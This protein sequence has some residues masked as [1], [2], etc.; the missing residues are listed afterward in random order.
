MIKGS[1]GWLLHALLL[2]VAFVILTWH[3]AQDVG[4][5][6]GA[7]G[8]ICGVLIAETMVAGRYRMWVI[9]V[10]GF[11]AIGLGWI[12]ARG[13]LGSITL[14]T[15]LGPGA[16]IK[17][18][19]V[20]RWSSAALGTCIIVRGTALRLR[21]A[22]AVEGS[23]AVAAVVATV[24]A[25]RDGM[26]AR[27]L[28]VSD[29]FWRQG[30]DPVV[31][32]L[33]VGIGAAMLVAGLLLHGRSRRR[34]LIQLSLVLMLALYLMSSIHRQE[35]PIPQK[36]AIG[37]ELEKSQDDPN[38]KSTGGGGT[39]GEPSGSSDQNSDLP[40]ASRQ[41]QN[42]PAAVVVFHRDVK[43]SGEVFYFRQASF[44]QF[45]GHRLVEATRPG[46]DTGGRLGFP[47]EPRSVE[48]APPSTSARTE[49]L[50]D[51]ALLLNHNRPFALLDP[52]QL[53]PKA[54]PDP[55]RFKR[56]YSVVSQVVTADPVE[57]LSNGAGDP[58]WDDQDWKLYTELPRDE[59]YYRL[60]TS[61]QAELRQEYNQSP[62]ALALAV[63]QHLEETS[64]YSFA[65]KYEGDEPTADFLF[66]E[67]R[68]G[69]C[70]HLAHSAAYL[71]RALGLPARVSAGYA[72]ESSN[73]S[74]GSALL[75]KQNHGHAWAEVYL[76]GVGWIPI[77]VTPQQ[78]DV[79]P[80][81]FEER[82]LQQLLGE[83]ARQEPPERRSSS[84]EWPILSWLSVLWA[85][86]PWLL[87]ALVVV[88]YII[89]FWRLLAPQFDARRP[90][91]AYRAALDR[92]SA[93]G[94]TRNHGE[95]REV[96]AKRVGEIAPSL[97]P[98]TAGLSGY[99]LGSV[100]PPEERAGAPLDRL[101]S[102]VGIEVRK[103]VPAW[104]WV[105]GMLNPLSWWWSR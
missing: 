99:V 26:I 84:S 51:V 78:T 58:G 54:N 63:K 61:L 65:R 62:L 24:A 103:A 102:T 19:E 76:T 69:Y 56:A 37:Q 93:V 10:T 57:F 33:T 68:K 39:G 14:A 40:Q 50:T 85:S 5:I 67:D 34:G 46:I 86:L 36:D 29:W 94:L 3:L 89:K 81:Q 8:A 60:A 104:R 25:H 70:V 11:V 38:R 88:F 42:R 75:I 53:A 95:A 22:L 52:V 27:P 59:R 43:P 55:G 31:A 87:A 20:L 1:R 15:A 6:A 74:G 16:A 96:F 105:L 98:L 4:L 82:D 30:I 48:G 17:V 28:V 64:T 9:W 83:M 71:M 100:R 77:E 92:L 90:M 18:G 66:S 7:M 80:D 13:L 21:V 32:F 41:K 23:V 45:N 44:S 101:A 35:N 47:A 79:E 2:A 49:V 91:V 97:E 73:L 12:V 72:V